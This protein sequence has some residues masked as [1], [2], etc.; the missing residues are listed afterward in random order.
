MSNSLAVARFLQ[1]HPK[2]SSVLHPGLSSHP[3]HE[4]A[5]KQSGGHSGIIAFY[6]RPEHDPLVFLKKLKIFTLAVSL[7]GVES[8]VAIP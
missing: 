5:K 3:G 7:G 1:K 4:L 8:L 6:L 2:V